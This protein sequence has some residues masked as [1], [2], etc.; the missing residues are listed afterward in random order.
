MN[1]EMARK[2]LQEA[3]ED[4]SARLPAEEH[5]AG[6]DCCRDFDRRLTRLHQ[7][8][9][10][11]PILTW[12]PAL[13]SR[14]ATAI[15]RERFADRWR[16]VAAAAAILVAAWLGV[17]ALPE[18]PGALTVGTQVAERITL[19]ESPGQILGGLAAGTSDALQ[20]I[21]STLQIASVGPGLAVAG[22]FV[23][24]LFNGI[25]IGRPVLARRRQS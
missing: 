24:L 25:L 16:T 13:T 9:E 20:T 23:L 5:L 11:D 1:C 22:I 18:V 7:V 19:P 10:S 4:A 3:L 2:Q 6:C 15:R 8:L 21:G 12:T 17:R 14:V